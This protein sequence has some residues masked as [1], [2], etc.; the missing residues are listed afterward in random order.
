[1]VISQRHCNLQRTGV[2]ISLTNRCT[3]MFCFWLTYNST[4]SVA[5]TLH[6]PLSPFGPS[7][8]NLD[9]DASGAEIEHSKGLGGPQFSQR[10]PSNILELR[11]IFFFSLFT[12]C[13]FC[14]GHGRIHLQLLQPV[15][16]LTPCPRSLIFL[17][18]R[19][20]GVMTQAGPS[21]NNNPPPVVY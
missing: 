13:Y 15:Q 5:P 10:V 16:V 7:G 4:I 21:V 9:D 11:S 18:Y 6:L 3:C 2:S 20:V 19:R 17:Q 12:S 8:S 1:M 14:R